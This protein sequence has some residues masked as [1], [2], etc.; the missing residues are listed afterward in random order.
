MATTKKSLL[1]SLECKMLEWANLDIDAAEVVYKDKAEQ[2]EKLMEE[3]EKAYVTLKENKS[4][5]ALTERQK[6]I[7]Q[8]DIKYFGVDWYAE[9]IELDKE[10]IQKLCMYAL[11][12]YHL[13]VRMS[14]IR[15]VV[16]INRLQ[17]VM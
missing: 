5:D 17:T 3:S 1:T 10:I 14:P 6:A 11:K 12:V 7:I 15:R 9:I 16:S 13:K 4:I 2:F 8:E